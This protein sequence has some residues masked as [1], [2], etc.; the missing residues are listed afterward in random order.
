[1]KT[2][3]LRARKKRRKRATGNG[4]FIKAKHVEITSLH[5]LCVEIH[6]GRM[7]MLSDSYTLSPPVSQCA[8]M[9]VHAQ[10]FTVIITFK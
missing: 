8:H 5:D 10:F 1:M 3:F 9:R 7:P 4:M 2:Y 6:Q